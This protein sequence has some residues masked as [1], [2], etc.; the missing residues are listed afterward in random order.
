MTT[1]TLLVGQSGGATAV[2]NASLA[3]V[4]DAASENAYGRVLGLQNGIEGLFDNRLIDLT[5]QPEGLI[6]GMRYTPSAALGTGRYKLKEEDLPRTVESMRDIGVTGFVYIGGNDSADTAYRI[7]EYAHQHGYDLRVMSVPKT[8]DNDLPETDFCPGYPS[9]ARFMGNAVRDA[10]YDSIASPHLYPVK[11]VETM[12]RDAGWVP[13]AGALA[14]GPDEVDLHPLILLPERRPPSVDDVLQM[15]QTDVDRRGFSVVVLP[16]TMKTASGDHF[17]GDTPEYIDG[18][19]HPYFP[20]TGAAMTRLTS[21]KLHLRARYDKPGTAARM[22]I[23]QASPLDLEVAYEL[24]SAA[25]RHM[26]DGGS[27]EMTAIRRTANDPFAY[28][29]VTVPQVA[30]ANEVRHL[31]AEFIGDDGVSVTDAFREYMH[32]LVGPDAFPPYVRLHAGTVRG[33]S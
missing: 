24:G 30:I 2:I 13:A 16:E 15:V 9:I 21:Q 5:A 17:G 33:E 22:S 28:D 26:A 18:F 3:G 25:V 27:G 10:V 1:P 6:E 20:S 12:G 14:F 7:G 19:G 32:P 23:S 8:I 4:V 31:D 11:Y 29:I